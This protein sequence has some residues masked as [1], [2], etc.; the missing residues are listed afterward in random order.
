MDKEIGG[1]LDKDGWHTKEER[2]TFEFKGRF[3]VTNVGISK[4][5]L[6]LRASIISICKISEKII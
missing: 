6:S 2:D 5:N 3:V 1:I 4:V